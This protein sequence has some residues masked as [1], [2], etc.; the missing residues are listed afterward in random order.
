M[1]GIY[2]AKLTAGVSRKQ[3][4]IVF[5]VRDDAR[6]TDLLMAQADPNNTD[7]CKG[8]CRTSV[9]DQPVRPR[10]RGRRR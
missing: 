8:S 3:Q 1:S 9:N 5:V 10:T 2:R 4:Y 6:A 7:R